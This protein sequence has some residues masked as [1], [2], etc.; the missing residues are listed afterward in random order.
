MYFISSLSSCILSFRR[1]SLMFILLILIHLPNCVNTLVSLAFFVCFFLFATVLSIFFLGS[2][3]LAA[4][5]MP[6]QIISHQLSNLFFVFVGT[7]A[8]LKL[9]DTFFR[10]CILIFFFSCWSSSAL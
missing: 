2:D 4:D 3:F 10:S 8:L 1:P 6:L 7:L 9:Y 5:C